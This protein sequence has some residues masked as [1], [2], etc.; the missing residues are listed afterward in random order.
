[1]NLCVDGFP[2]PVHQAL[3]RHGAR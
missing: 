2:P 3:T 1:M